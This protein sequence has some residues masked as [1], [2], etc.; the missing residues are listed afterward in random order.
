[1]NEI[2][3]ARISQDL[4]GKVAIVTEA[5]SRAKGVG[6]GRAVATML[7]EVKQYLPISVRPPIETEA[8]SHLQP[9]PV[10]RAHDPAHQTTS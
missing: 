6:N 2:G 4:R 5:G 10:L 9:V 1:M 8:V 7:A 3:Q